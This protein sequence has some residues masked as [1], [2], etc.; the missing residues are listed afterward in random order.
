M[1]E[2]AR[3]LLVMPLGT[4]PMMD[5][6]EEYAAKVRRNVQE[7][8][9]HATYVGGGDAPPF[10]YST[11]L[12]ETHRIPELII[13][14]LPSDLS[15]LLMWQYAERFKGDV[16]AVNQRI[17]KN[18]EQFDFFLIPVR[19]DKVREIALAS[20]KYYGSHPFD[21]LQLVHPDLA[22]LFPHEDGYVYE[23]EIIG[24][25]TGITAA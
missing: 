10:C 18:E 9:F 2:R 24:D 3:E 5:A 13:S 15:G 22:G 4:V 21:C 20:L 14:G 19:D 7:Y 6:R 16:L 23:Q 1:G 25:Y 12:F 8:G 17:E 11:G